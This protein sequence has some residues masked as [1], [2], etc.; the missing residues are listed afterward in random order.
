MMHSSKRGAAASLIA[1]LALVGSSS[2]AVT[3]HDREKARAAAHYVVAQQSADGEIT[4]GF[5][6]IG[7]TADATVSLVAARRGPRAITKAVDYLKTHEAEVDTVG[8]NAKV[9]QALVA[10]GSS[11]RD[12]E[13]RNL[14]KEIKDS[15]LGDGHFGENTEVYDQANA[16]IALRA[17]RV[18]PSRA[19]LQWLADA[20]CPDGGWAFDQ[21]WSQG[22][23]AHCNN[24][25][26]FDSSSD[27]NTTSLAVHAFQAKTGD[28]GLGKSPFAFFQ[29]ARDP[30]KHGW[31]YSPEFLTDTNSTALVIQA[32]AV[33]DRGLPAGAKRAMRRLQ[34]PLCEED[35]AFA[36]NWVEND[37][38]TY[39]RSEPNVGA[40][41]QG[42]LGLLE[43][44]YPVRP[45][46]V[47]RPA[48]GP[49]C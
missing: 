9:I 26:Q 40:T 18:A 29:A 28:V 38:G 6:P 37:D 39:S 35:G 41:M 46:E 30:K 21:P 32:Y 8:E 3:Q 33:A 27:T 42:I 49:S 24:G 4:N 22:D 47:T 13:G 17:A 15:E 2:A 16:L 48:R 43:R 11:P 7:T 44:P 20:Q 1:S 25:E 23:D 31:G 45:A 36:F 12:F 19:S 10:A 14:V 5:S 34:Y